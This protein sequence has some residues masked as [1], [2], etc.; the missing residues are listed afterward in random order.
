MQYFWEIPDW[1]IDDR[2]LKKLR[3]MPFQRPAPFIPNGVGLYIVRGPRQIGKSSWLKTVLSYYAKRERCFYLS[4]ENVS[5]SQELSEILKSIRDRK[6]VLLDEVNFVENWDRAIKHEVDSG[7]TNILMVTGSHSHDLRKGADRM[8]G[9][10][11]AGG[12]FQLLPMNFEEFE[13]ARRQAKWDSKDRL[14]ELQTYFRVGGFPTAIAEAG[15]T[16]RKPAR[17]IDTTLKWLIGDATRLGKQET[18]LRE[19]LAQ[20]AICI[21]TP[22]SLQTLAKKTSIG[23]HNTIQEYLAILESC[24]ALRQLHA[25]D[26][27]TGAYRFRKD[28]KFYFSDPLFYLMAIEISGMGIPENYDSIIAELVANEALMRRFPKLG[29]WIGKQGEVDFIVPKLWAIEVK[30]SPV[31]SNLSKAYLNLVLPEK[32][33][34][35]H[36]NFLR[37]WP[38]NGT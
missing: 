36:S 28:R 10:F 31:A 11:D 6:V 26:I 33:V 27:D 14:T 37:E 12:E 13:I 34:W 7:H 24:F 4:C 1:E 30:W 15:P 32:I 19:I 5:G 35:T 3:E 23:S 16:G 18:Y 21:Q 29:Y 38:R 17:A 8:P 9:R 2:H 25:I 20:L 22:L